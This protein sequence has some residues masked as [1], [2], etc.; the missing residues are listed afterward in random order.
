MALPCQQ[1]Y[2]KGVNC[3]DKRAYTAQDSITYLLNLT[4]RCQ[5]VMGAF[6]DS[7]IYSMCTPYDSCADSFF[8]E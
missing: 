7:P 6:V 1:L 4:G 2:C 3:F 5:H 8:N